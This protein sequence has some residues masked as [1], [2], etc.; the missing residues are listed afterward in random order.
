MAA[1]SPSALVVSCMSHRCGIMV[2][3]GNASFE[4]IYTAGA[5]DTL[6]AVAG[7]TERSRLFITG[8]VV[9]WRCTEANAKWQTEHDGRI[10]QRCDMQLTTSADGESAA[11]FTRPTQCSTPGVW[12]AQIDNA[13]LAS[14]TLDRI[15]M[16]RAGSF[17]VLATGRSKDAPADGAYFNVGLY[18]NAGATLVLLAQAV[19]SA[20]GQNPLAANGRMLSF[21]AD[22]YLVY[23]F[24]SLAGSLGLLLDQCWFSV[25]EVLP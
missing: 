25:Q 20:A 19:T 23:Q 15:T 9:I 7:G 4:L 11:T 17:M 22:D 16:R 24:R 6:D 14:V 12:T 1:D 2:S 5:G 8:E 10:P 21:V 3:T 13:S 18:K